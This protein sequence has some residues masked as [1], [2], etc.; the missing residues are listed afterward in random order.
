MG[1]DLTTA[2]LHSSIPGSV[3]RHAYLAAWA[4]ALVAALPSCASSSVRVDPESAIAEAI[5]SGGAIAFHVEGSRTDEDPLDAPTLSLEDAIRLALETHPALQGSLA[6]VRVAQA[7]ADEASLVPNPV[8]DVILRIDEGGGL[9]PEIAL[10]TDLVTLLRRPRNLRAAE[11]RL[12]AEAANSLG[13]ALDILREVQTHYSAVQALEESVEILHE[14][15]EIVE[16]LRLV[17]KARFDVGEGQRA[18]LETFEIEKR[19]LEIEAAET[20]ND[21]RLERLALARL[22]GRPS[23]AAEWSVEKWRPWS[24][25]L[26][27]ES[28]WVD[29]ALS[30][31]PEIQQA[32]WELAAR[33][34]ELAVAS[35]SPL[36]GTAVGVAVERDDEWSAGPSLSVPLAWSGRFK[37]R[38]ERALAL[39]A[40]SRHRLTEVQR[41]TVEQVRTAFA[42]LSSSQANLERLT[43]EL[44]PLLERRRSDVE[45]AY[46]A[47][48][49]DVTF[50]LRADQALRES[51]ARVIDLERQASSALYALQ[52]TVGGPAAFDRAL[53]VGE[54]AGSDD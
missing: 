33:E 5:P 38:R 6:R 21:R 34:E 30:T 17:A 11:N 8:L 32:R 19:S 27:E 9:R 18:D 50:L 3:Q 44:I 49:V 13:T 45:R 25:A 35:S 47:R 24:E 29:T 41:E 39:Q 23:D 14:Q 10:T 40:E 7:E 2:S 37:A 42:T 26:G 52:H 36:E 22:I 4:L 16:R 43:A 15:V 28:T 51:R 46:E 1:S 31:R 54:G 12:R 20:A 48:D 53:A